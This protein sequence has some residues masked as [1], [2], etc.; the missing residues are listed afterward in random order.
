MSSHQEIINYFSTDRCLTSQQFIQRFG[1]IS[2]NQLAS[3]E[4]HLEFGEN[5]ICLKEV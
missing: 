1:H 4:G 5:G 3:L 2:L